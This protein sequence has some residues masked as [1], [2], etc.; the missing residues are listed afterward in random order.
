MPLHRPLSLRLRLLLAAALVITLHAVGS[1]TMDVRDARLAAHQQQEELGQWVVAGL[2]DSLANALVVN[3]LATVQSTVERLFSGRRFLQLAVF[4]EAGRS[5]IDLRAK[6]D[7]QPDVP[8]WFIRFLDINEAPSKR[9][10]SAGGVQYGVVVALIS[11]ATA[12][13]HAW[14]NIKSA[15]GFALLAM[16]LFWGAFTLLIEFSMRPLAELSQTVHRI[17]SGDFTAKAHDRGVP[18]FGDLVRVINLMTQQLT[19]LIARTREQAASEIQA[20]RLKDFH[21]IT[22]GEQENIDKLSALL[23]MGLRHFGMDGGAAA[24]QTTN[25]SIPLLTRGQQAPSDVLALCAKLRPAENQADALALP[26]LSAADTDGVGALLAAPVAFAGRT[27]GTVCFWRAQ[28][29]DTAFH[30]V[31]MEF[32]NLIGQWMGFSLEQEG[33]ERQLWEEKERLLVTLASIGDAVVATD[34]AGRITFLN[35]IAEDLIAVPLQDAKGYRLDE[36]C[37]LVHEHTRKPIPNPIMDC[38][39]KGH[40]V[41]L[42]AH[43]ALVRRDGTECP[44][45]DSA[46]PIF[47][48]D[49][50]IVGAVMVF[51][52]VTE[53]RCVANQMEHLASHD[54]L[55]NLPNRRA[56]G[57]NLNRVLTGAKCGSNKTHALC[58]IDLDH[59]KAVNDTCGHAAGD[60]LLQQVAQLFLENLRGTDVLARLGGDEFGLILAHVSEEQAL[61]TAERICTAVR[62][63]NFG[64]G[65]RIFKIGASIGL[66]LVEQ[67]AQSTDELIRQADAACYEAKHGGRSRVCPYRAALDQKPADN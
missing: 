56:F 34:T 25:A 62:D 55:T 10:L 26:N 61:E 13:E 42:A 21:A 63:F 48:L 64:W 18:E 58:F 37:N 28:P 9:M 8:G 1:I 43:G 57:E 22:T 36:I 66:A 7:N 41:E 45:E 4:D 47:S 29:Q 50:Q 6:I 27:Y 40:R 32:V 60:A 16:A 30:R 51:R 31:D 24:A 35:A 19:D 14:A 20:G 54:P 11:P 67:T 59:F 65:G 3:D 52:D 33:S 46:A 44:I 2:G 49:G 39:E 53:S 12:V 5:I 15:A 23:E 38:L 17:G